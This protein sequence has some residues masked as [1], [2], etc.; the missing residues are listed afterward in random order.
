VRKIFDISGQKK[1]FQTEVKQI[2]LEVVSGKKIVV[3]R[4]LL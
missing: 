2:A 4:E 3:W 1:I